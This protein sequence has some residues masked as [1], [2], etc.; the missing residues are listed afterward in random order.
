MDRQQ[1]LNGCWVKVKREMKC[2]RSDRISWRK[3]LGMSLNKKV[4]LLKEIGLDSIQV[5]ERIRTTY[6]LNSEALR[7]LKIGIAARFGEQGIVENVQNKGM[8]NEK[9][10]Y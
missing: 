7:R 4:A 10:T 2:N 6:K 1:D 3:I 9:D 8:K 5:Y